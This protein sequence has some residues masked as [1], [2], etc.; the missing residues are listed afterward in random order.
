MQRKISTFFSTTKGNGNSDEH[1]ILSK[2]RTK[3]ITIPKFN[4]D[5]FTNNLS[6]TLENRLHAYT[7]ANNRVK[8]FELILLLQNTDIMLS[9]PNTSISLLKGSFANRKS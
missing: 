5:A 4:L 9:L 1:S 6:G 7:A 2:L 8:V 3:R